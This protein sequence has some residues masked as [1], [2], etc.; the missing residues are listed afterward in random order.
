MLNLIFH[1][2]Q[3]VIRICFHERRLQ[4]AE[5][6]QMALWQSERPG[7]RIVEVDVPL[8]LG[9][10]RVVQPME[11]HLLNTVEVFWDPVKEAGVC[12]KVCA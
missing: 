1:L 11:H 10:L 4:F 3:S 9:L 6:E 8:S 7:E 5:R 12:I 2:L